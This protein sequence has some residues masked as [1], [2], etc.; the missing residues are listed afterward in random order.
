M[1]S[2]DT[3]EQVYA[4]MCGL[5]ADDTC[6]PSVA[7]AFSAGKRCAVLS[8]EI[9]NARLRLSQRFHIPF[10]DKDLEII[11]NA[12][13]TI[14]HELCLKMYQYGRRLPDCSPSE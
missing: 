9:Y 1:D 14:Q 7:N 4:T 3:P 10:E 8:D 12:Y 2:M 5:L 11:V 13:L 6:I